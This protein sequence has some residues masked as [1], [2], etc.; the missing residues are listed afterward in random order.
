MK[1]R[2]WSSGDL[3][4]RERQR[5]MRIV[6][7]LFIVRVLLPAFVVW[8]LFILAGLAIARAWRPAVDTNGW[9]F[10]VAFF[11]P[12][13]VVFVVASAFCQVLLIRWLIRYRTTRR[14]RIVAMRDVLRPSDARLSVWRRF[15]LYLYGVTAEDLGL[16]SSLWRP[17]GA[18]R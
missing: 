15:W 18:A 13:C 4:P 11:V 14:G 6:S 16:L 7:P 8:W 12:S 1:P 17:A 10:I 3:T 9:P 5:L 2:Y